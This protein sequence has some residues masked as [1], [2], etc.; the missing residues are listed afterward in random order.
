MHVTSSRG[1]DAFAHA[2]L[3]GPNDRQIQR[4]GAT[5][6]VQHPDVSKQVDG[7]LEVLFIAGLSSGTRVDNRTRDLPCC[8]ERGSHRVGISMPS[9]PQRAVY[10]QAV[11]MS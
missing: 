5:I 11:A 3:L 6:L 10:S 4:S 1:G 2:V 8:L 9:E 7:R